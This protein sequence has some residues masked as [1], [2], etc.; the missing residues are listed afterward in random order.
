MLAKRIIACLDVKDGRVVK[1]K[2]FLDLQ[3]QG[4]P[5]AIAAHYSEQG[6]DEIVFLDVSATIQGRQALVDVMRKT[7][8]NVFVPLTVGGGIKSVK[9]AETLFRNG[10]DKI[11]VN[12]AAIQNPALVT[13]LARQFGSQSV[14]A[15]IDAKKQNGGWNAFTRA[16]T[17][18]A[19][20][21][22]VAWA[23][24]VQELGAGEILLT[25]MDRDGMQ[26]GFDLEL[27]GK[28][29]K[30][31]SIP[32]VASGGAG[33]MR[34]YLEAL[35]VADAALGAST[36]HSGKIEIPKLKAYLEKQGLVIR[37]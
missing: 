12:S 32:V 16:G 36:F 37:L 29:C 20:L 26:N 33:S 11:S 10:A 13:E 8:E 9:D 3:D 15:A 28:V 4:D 34:D 22:A 24:R 31:V 19:G 25:S 1:G 18:D 27:L 5:A 17:T 35:K 14:V 23:K 30:A 2:K 7:A 21:D 6:A